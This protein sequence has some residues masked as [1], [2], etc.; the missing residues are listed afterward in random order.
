MPMHI[1]PSKIYRSRIEAE[2]HARAAHVEIANL[3]DFICDGN[4]F[5]QEGHQRVITIG[6]LDD[7]RL[8]PGMLTSAGCAKVYREKVSGAKTDR[9][10]LAK[11]T[12]RLEPGDVLVV[13]RLEG[14]PAQPVTF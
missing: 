13:T 9:A 11:V 2:Q 3:I 6:D 1:R 12:G 8:M 10:E 7:Y 4:R 5:A 14:P